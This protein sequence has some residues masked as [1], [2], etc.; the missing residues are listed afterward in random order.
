MS[1]VLTSVAERGLSRARS[2]YFSAAIFLLLMWMTTAQSGNMSRVRSAT[3]IQTL[4]ASGI[5]ALAGALGFVFYQTQ[6]LV[7]RR[8]TLLGDHPATMEAIADDFARAR[9]NACLAFFI[10]C[11]LG[12]FL[13]Q[14]EH[15]YWDRLLMLCPLFLFLCSYPTPKDV[16]RF[17]TVVE[18]ARRLYYPDSPL[19]M[20]KSSVDQQEADRP[21][22]STSVPDG[23]TVDQAEAARD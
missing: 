6:T 3:G 16:V 15:L 23:T 20:E 7:R 9:G 22:L 12:L 13:M 17:A 2:K 1:E 5:V 8:A 21:L 18:T 10:P 14:A 19:M 4:R 11:C